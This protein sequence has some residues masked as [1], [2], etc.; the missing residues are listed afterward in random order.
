MQQQQMALESGRQREN[1]L[2]RLERALKLTDE[3]S[4]GTCPRCEEDI[5]EKRLSAL[6]DAVFCISC[7]E[8]LEKK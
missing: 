5:G 1:L 8:A 4:Y 6:P 2:A 3:G 7:A